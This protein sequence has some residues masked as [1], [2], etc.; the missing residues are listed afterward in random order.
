LGALVWEE[1]PTAWRFSYAQAKNLEHAWRAVIRR[2]INHPCIITWVP[3]NEA[4]GLG[5]FVFGNFVINP[6][7]LDFEKHMA[8]VTRGLDPTRLVI[9]NSGWDHT[10]LTDV[11]D[12]HHYLPTLEAAQ[13]LYDELADLSTYQWSLLRLIQDPYHNNIFAPGAS[14]QGQP[15]LISEYGGFG[16]YDWEEPGEVVDAYRAAT[17]LIQAQPHIDGYCYTQ[18]ND[19][20]QEQNG[21]VDMDR[22]PILP[23]EDIREINQ[24][25]TLPR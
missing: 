22:N 16:W 3:Y 24:Q 9:D 23:P 25:R 17:E 19:T 4:W 14:Y 15:I 20:Y 6:V 18:F 13:A 21:L 7:A 2:D 12:I 5:S 11:V 1:M 10:N 8:S